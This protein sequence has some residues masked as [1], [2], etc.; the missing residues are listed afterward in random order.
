[1]PAGLKLLVNWL[2]LSAAVIWLGAIFANLLAFLPA[3]RAS[4]LGERERVK[5]RAAYLQTFS[6]T[7][8]ITL[9]ILLL[10]GAVKLY[11]HA[12]HVAPGL[13]A[14]PWGRLLVLKWVLIAIMIGGGAYSTY[15]LVPSL[16]TTKR[17][18][19]SGH[20]MSRAGRI[21]SRTNRDASIQRRLMVIGAV[22]VLLGL[23]LLWIIKL[24]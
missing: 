13:A 22:N 16:Q 7:A 6:L 9:T 8:W 23:C 4:G 2:H 17:T 3:L 1:M 21:S 24:L 18:G 5:L 19:G 20:T 12:D 15:V 14:T 11:L 10:S